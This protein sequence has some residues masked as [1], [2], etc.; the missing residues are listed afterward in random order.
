MITKNIIIKEACVDSHERA[1]NVERNGADRIELCQNLDL[2]GL[3][4]NINVIKRTIQSVKIPVK[5]MIR[6]R[7]GNFIYN[8]NEIRSMENDIELCKNINVTEVV[9]GALT[10]ERSIDIE[11]IKK[12]ASKA[13]PMAITFHKAIDETDNILNALS[14]LSKVQ[15]ISSILTSGGAKTAIDGQIM[16]NKIIDQ[17]NNRFNIIV[18]GSIT[19]E[20]FNDIHSLI[21]A[22]EYHGKNLIQ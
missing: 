7:S 20:N 1:I 15:N 18:A 2:E 22:K 3:T 6:P 21:N 11:K 17:Y 13:Y 16:L 9:F 19:H 14:K 8:Q 5:I 4:P 10:R 12:L